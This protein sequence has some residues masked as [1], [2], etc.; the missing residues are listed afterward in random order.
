MTSCIEG[1]ESKQLFS[2]LVSDS[3]SNSGSDSN[4]DSDAAS[5]NDSGSNVVTRNADNTLLEANESSLHIG[6]SRL[7]T[8]IQGTKQSV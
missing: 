5:E 2:L 7:L 4:A 8:V 3:D 1:E 6:Q